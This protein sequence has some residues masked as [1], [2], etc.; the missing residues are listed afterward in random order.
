MTAEPAA[1]VEERR[2]RRGSVDV[3]LARLLADEVAPEDLQTL[4]HGV[5]AALGRSITRRRAEANKK[6][7]EGQREL[8]ALGGKVD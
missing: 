7:A 2:K 1:A 3:V 6:V 4:Q 8:G 5:D